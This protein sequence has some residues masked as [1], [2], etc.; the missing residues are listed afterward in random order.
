MRPQWVRLSLRLPRSCRLARCIRCLAFCH[1]RRNTPQRAMATDSAIRPPSQ[2]LVRLHFAPEQGYLLLNAAGGHGRL[3]WYCQF[4]PHGIASNSPFAPES[5]LC[6]A[7]SGRSRSPVRPS[8]FLQQVPS[9]AQV[10]T[11]DT[12]GNGPVA[13]N[14]RRPVDRR[15]AQITPTNVQL[16]NSA[17]RRQDPPGPHP[18]PSG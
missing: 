4:L 7:S 13:S 8:L 3:P 15:Y 18:H 14:C 1:S 12:S 10:I 6:P 9:A 16:A 17:A 2:S 5:R 11:I